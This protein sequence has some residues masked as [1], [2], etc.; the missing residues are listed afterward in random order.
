MPR[1]YAETQPR[2]VNKIQG[3]ATRTEVLYI[4]TTNQDKL[5]EFQR[6]IP[7]KRIEGVKLGVDEAQTLDHHEVVIKKAKLAFEK[8]GFNP[9]LVE[10][11]SFEIAGLNNRPG[12]FAD[13]FISE[14]EMRR[15]IA[16]RW[17]KDKDRRASAKVKLAIYDGTDVFVFEGITDGEIAPEPKGNSF[18]FDDIFIPDG[19]KG[20]S[21]LTFAQMAP[22]MKDKNSM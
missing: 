5:R 17:L 18:G 11:T 2:I 16:T 13:F 12:P 9:I 4:A 15:D 8:Y 14:P 7:H 20:K 10:D 22:Y 21:K 1:T 3:S 19:Q 6:L